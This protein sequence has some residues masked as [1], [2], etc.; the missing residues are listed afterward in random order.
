[1]L[2]RLSSLPVPDQQKALDF[3]TG[4]LGFVKKHDVPLGE[5]RWITV[6]AADEQ[7]G[8]ELVLEPMA[9]APAKA[10]YDALFEAGIPAAAFLVT[11]VQQEYERLVKKNV[12]FSVPPTP[13][14]P[15]TIAVFDDT[16]GHMI[17]IYQV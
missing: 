9:F 6:V 4:I 10:Y 12:R 14:G 11:D 1:M 3:Y 2:I 7:D 16:C 17:Q 8:T 13:M 5:H 15:V